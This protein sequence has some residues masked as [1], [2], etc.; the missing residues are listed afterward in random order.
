MRKKETPRSV[1]A[2][3]VEGG[4][5]SGQKKEDWEKTYG[6]VGWDV[7]SGFEE[8]LLDAEEDEDEE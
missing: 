6:E 3:R 4:A 2:R 8:G 5:D 7:E 1:S